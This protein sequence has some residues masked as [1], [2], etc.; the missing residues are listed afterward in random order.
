MTYKW[1]R[2]E[3]VKNVIGININLVTFAPSFVVSGT[4]FKLSL[5]KKD[6][7]TFLKSGKSTRGIQI[8]TF[9]NN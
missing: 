5:F 1:R 8:L 7:C 6:L 2:Y 4:A 3:S 9:H